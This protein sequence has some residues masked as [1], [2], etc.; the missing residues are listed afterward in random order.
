MCGLALR[1]WTSRSV[2]HA[3]SEAPSALTARLHVAV[4]TLA[5]ER[6]QLG[7]GLQIPVVVC[8]DRRDRV[9]GRRRDHRA[10]IAVCAVGIEQRADRKAVAH[11]M[12]PGPARSRAR[13]DPGTGSQRPEGSLHVADGQ[14]GADG[15]DQQRLGRT[16][17]PGAVPASEVARQHAGRCRV[18]RQ[19]SGLAELP[20]ADDERPEAGVEVG[21]EPARSP[22]DPHPGDDQQPEQRPKR[23][24]LVRAAQRAG[25]FDQPQDLLVGVEVG[26]RTRGRSGSRSVV[27]TST[28]GST[29]RR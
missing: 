12:Q 14:P 21:V 22:P 19:L 5:G 11:V 7:R 13:Q 1:S 16:S 25:G 10:G 3:C 24:R 8:R 9:G 2:N 20:V 29:S 18:Q 27:G 23:R 26:D 28:R 15:R 6:H 4:Q 17:W